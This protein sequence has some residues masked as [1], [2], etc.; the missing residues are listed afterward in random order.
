LELARQAG[1]PISLAA[2]A[3]DEIA[4]KLGV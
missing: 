4:E 3:L 1:L 2:N